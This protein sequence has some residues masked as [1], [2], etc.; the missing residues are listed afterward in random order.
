MRIPGE[1][2]HLR[3]TAIVIPVRVIPIRV[4]RRNPVA[5]AAGT[6]RSNGIEH[7]VT[8]WLLII[9]GP[10]LI[11]FI[12]R[13]IVPIFAFRALFVPRFTGQADFSV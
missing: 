9:I 11:A 8:G 13:N 6:L 7:N 2:I 4:F 10:N 5:S 1:I 12:G 3:V